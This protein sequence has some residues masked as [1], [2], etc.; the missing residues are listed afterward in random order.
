MNAIFLSSS[1]PDRDP[2]R[3]QADP[4]AVREAVLALAAVWLPH[5]ELVFGG[6][7]AISPL[8]EHAGRSLGHLERVH[9]YQSR[10]F[11]KVIPAA[12]KAFVNLH[13][14]APGSD[15]ATSLTNMRWEMLE[16]PNNPRTFQAAVFIGGMDGIDEELQ[17]FEKVHSQAAL[18]P[19][20]STG[21]AAYE[22]W[23]RGV[24]LAGGKARSDLLTVTRY[25]KLFRNLLF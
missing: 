20:G 14:T 11:E 24:G 18:I 23:N 16:S 1:V 21:A 19:V 15:R 6:H 10:F 2:W 22:L 5:G 9:I 12:A 13:W 25:R 4:L 17:I 7:P 3:K 8:V